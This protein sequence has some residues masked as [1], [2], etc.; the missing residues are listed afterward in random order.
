LPIF[1][2]VYVI[3]LKFFKI[4]FSILK[5]ILTILAST[6]PIPAGIFGPSFVLGAAIGRFIGEIMVL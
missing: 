4:F 6:L 3:F 2:G 1:I 5:F